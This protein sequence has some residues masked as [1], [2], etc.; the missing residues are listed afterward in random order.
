M[1]DETVSTLSVR[2]D[3]AVDPLQFPV[4]VNQFAFQPALPAHPAADSS[5]VLMTLGYLA[6]PVISPNLSA[7]AAAEMSGQTMVLPIVGAGR[8]V[9]SFD[10]L[11]VLSRMLTEFVEQFEEEAE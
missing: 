6:S 9:L 10:D 5:Q 7:E 2:G 4:P 1:S 11:R 8:F 3:W